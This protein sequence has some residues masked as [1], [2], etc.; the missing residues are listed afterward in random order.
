MVQ[1]GY[2]LILKSYKFSAS[3][4]FFIGITCNFDNYISINSCQLFVFKQTS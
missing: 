1:L 2:S 4:F 3:K